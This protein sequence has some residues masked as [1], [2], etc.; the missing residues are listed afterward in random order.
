MAVNAWVGRALGR[1][2]RQ[3]DE[4][5][6]T[7][8][9]GLRARRLTLPPTEGPSP[10]AE[11][12]DS[13]G[14]WLDETVGRQAWPRRRVP[15]PRHS[16]SSTPGSRGPVRTYAWS[17]AIAAAPEEGLLDLGALGADDDPDVAWILRSNLS[18]AR[19]RTVLDRR[20]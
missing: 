12:L 15:R 19:L 8:V 10:G 6:A 16:C 7:P 18:K 3:E 1:T 5:E 20:S 4:P 9:S 2:S 14:A 17:V 13:V 11:A